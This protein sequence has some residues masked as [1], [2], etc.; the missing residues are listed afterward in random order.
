MIEVNS[1]A[2]ATDAILYSVFMRLGWAPYKQYVSKELL[3]RWQLATNYEGQ[4]FW[5]ENED[6]VF[7]N[8]GHDIEAALLVDAYNYIVRGKVW[9][10]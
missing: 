4:V 6:Q 10:V 3:H 5:R 1:M 7:S 2:S 9:K 8:A